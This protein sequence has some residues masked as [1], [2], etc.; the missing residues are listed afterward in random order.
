M[1][2]KL[3]IKLV[4]GPVF[5]AS[6]SNHSRIIHVCA[7]FHLACPGKRDGLMQISVPPSL[8]APCKFVTTYHLHGPY[9]PHINCRCKPKRGPHFH[10]RI[11]RRTKAEPHF[12]QRVPRRPP[13][14][15]QNSLILMRFDL[16]MSSYLV[17]KVRHNLQLLLCA[18]LLLLLLQSWHRCCC[19]CCCCC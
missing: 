5:V 7:L 6:S 15:L 18:Q 17:L 1:C 19:C 9:S 13:S 2:V 16:S 3:N 4:E 14:P 11:P 12:H 8:P 10:Q